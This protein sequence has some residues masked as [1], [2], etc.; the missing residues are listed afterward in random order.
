MRG[1]VGWFGKTVFYDG[2]YDRNVDF[3]AD[4]KTRARIG[5]SRVALKNINEF[6]NTYIFNIKSWIVVMQTFDVGTKLPLQYKKTQKHFVL[7]K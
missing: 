1:Y 7:L 5:G 2:T 6:T 4:F 3:H